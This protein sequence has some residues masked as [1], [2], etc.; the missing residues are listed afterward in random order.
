MIWP[1]Q[2]FWVMVS[3]FVNCSPELLNSLD[4]RNIFVVSI[5]NDYREIVKSF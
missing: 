5:V 1:H 4:E 2:F 3:I